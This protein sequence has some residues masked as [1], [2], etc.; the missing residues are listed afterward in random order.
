MRAD[1]LFLFLDEAGNFD[2]SPKGTPLFT[3]TCLAAQDVSPWVLPLHLLKHEI[4]ASGIG[5]ERFH[6]TEDFQWVRDRAFAIL[7]ATSHARV[8]SAIIYKRQIPTAFHSLE[9]LYPA[10]CGHLLKEVLSGSVLD[11]I[12]TVVIIFDQIGYKEKRHDISKGV[13]ESLKPL[14]RPG[15]AYHLYFHDT[16]S[17]AYLQAVD[18]FSWA[19]YVK[20]ARGERRPYEA[21]KHAIAGE[22]EVSLG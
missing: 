8:H 16:R 2:F 11:N 18:Y 3:L 6:A 7:S 21:I 22:T 15:L 20:W 19:I 17:N 9:R 12:H 1:T 5:I 10:A 13:K 14:L 4:N